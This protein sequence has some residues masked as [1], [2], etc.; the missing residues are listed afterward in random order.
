MSDYT[1]LKRLAEDVNN[2]FPEKEDLWNM[3]CTPTVALGLIADLESLK[4]EIPGWTERELLLIAE[5]EVLLEVA[6]RATYE[7]WSQLP[8]YVPWVPGGNSLKQ[9][10]ARAMV[11]AAISKEGGRG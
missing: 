10:E 1:E 3:V 2:N 7:T 6:A 9:D 11:R 5:N 4:A 8:G